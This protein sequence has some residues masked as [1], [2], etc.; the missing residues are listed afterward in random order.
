MSQQVYNNDDHE[1]SSEESGEETE[2]SEEDEEP[3]LKYQR[4]GNSVIE[5]LKKDLASCLAVTSKFLVCP[6]HHNN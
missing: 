4:L 2:S 5:I 1:K 3:K 6:P